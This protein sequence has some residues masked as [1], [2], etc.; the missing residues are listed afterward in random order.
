MKQ[1]VVKTILAII[2]IVVGV[3]VVIKPHY[4]NYRA[5]KE[6]N[7]LIVHFEDNLYEERG[8]IK[9]SDSSVSD[10]DS[11]E[12]EIVEHY[13]WDESYYVQDEYIPKEEYM[14]YQRMKAYNEKI[15][16]ENQ[17]GMTDP[18]TLEQ[19]SVDLSEFG[20]TSGLL[21]YMTIPA[22]DVEMPIY[23][24]ATM[25]NLNLGAANLSQT[26]LPIG[27]ENTNSVIAAHRGWKGKR[28][29]RDVE[30][31][32]AGDRVYIT[33]AW[34]TITYAV[35]KKVLIAPNDVSAIKIQEGRDMITL[36]TC[37]PFIGHYYRYL[38]YCVRVPEETWPNYSYTEN[39]R[40][41]SADSITPT[42]RATY[43]EEGNAILSNTELDTMPD[44]TDDVDVSSNIN[45]KS[46]RIQIFLD[47]Y[48]PMIVIGVLLLIFAISM[49]TSRK[50]KKKKSKPVK[51]VSADSYPEMPKDYN[52]FQP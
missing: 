37:H 41:M 34:E 6:A 3:S 20:N 26:S 28:F 46:S 24:G 4:E 44:G 31:L 36:F 5:E 21:G 15:Y 12:D 52:P 14:L 1:T 33:N 32:A 38:V 51:V 40:H 18:W 17:S 45:Y 16:Q 2:I 10:S 23:L 7:S 50:P 29:L 43:A 13:E 42:Q 25:D 30:E 22:I 27:G 9:E 48:A 19:Q 35:A 8:P 39:Q 47:S 11:N 49:L